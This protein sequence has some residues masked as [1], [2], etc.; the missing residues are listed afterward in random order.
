MTD[1]LII[2]GIEFKSRLWVGTGKYKNFEETARAIEASGTDVVT[3]A[4]RRVNII[5]RSQENLLD[6]IDPKKYKILPNTA[7]CYTV[8]D[9]LRYARLAREAGVSDMIKL[10]VIGDEKTLFPDVC[11]LLK[12]TEI[13]AKEGFIV[14]P[15]TNDDPITAKRLVD[16][17]AAAVM[18]LGAP[19]GSGLGIR[20]P[21]N[22]KIILETVD[23]PV[24]VDAG[25]GTASDVAIAMELGCD[26]VLVNTAI[27]GAKDP[28]MMAEALK[29]ACIAGRLAYKAGRIPKKLY[30]SASSPIEGMLI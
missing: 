13:L 23:V 14:L 28:I 19:I 22:I 30:A 9:A 12:A 24:I 3:V 11:G 20:N 15:Y 7:G 26:A 2:K 1:P 6:Y 10:E 5:D 29:H 18:P 27:A 21:Y 8:E 25:V 17:G 16:A 4:V